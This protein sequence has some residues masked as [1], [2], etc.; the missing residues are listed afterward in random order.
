MRSALLLFALSP[1]SLA[2]G[3]IQNIAAVDFYGQ[4][5]LDIAA[6]RS[7]LPLHEGD[8][9]PQSDEAYTKLVERIKSTVQAVMGIEATDVAFSCCEY[10]GNWTVFVGL[11]GPSVHRIVYSA[12]PR[13]KVTLPAGGIR[14]YEL[15]MDAV[16]MASR[17]GARS[18]ESMGYSLSSDPTLR[19]R[20]LEM[21]QYARKHENAI[22]L[23]LANSSESRQ[24]AAAAMLLG[25]SSSP[26]RQIALLIEASRD[27]NGLVRNNAV[28]S[29]ALMAG[30]DAR[31]AKRIPAAPFIEFLKSGSWQDRDKG[32]FLLDAITASR[33]PGL[34]RLLRAEAVDPLLEMAQWHAQAGPALHVLRRVARVDNEQM[35]QRPRADQI[36]LI[37]DALHGP[38]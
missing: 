38:G 4:T 17:S 29:L 16:L 28:R 3:P 13:Q 1:L 8:P 9:L 33:D 36:Q 32:S 21:R 18:N 20:Q 22:R 37:L 34:L 12:P 25:Y 14:I 30:A 23:V 19:A 5:G 11:S 10:Q 15:A 27:S 26:Q 7:A 2:Q 6:L 35:S 24:R 31:V